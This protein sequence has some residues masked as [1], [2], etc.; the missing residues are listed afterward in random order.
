MEIIPIEHAT[1]VLKWSGKVI[2]TDPVSDSSL[3]SGEPEPDIILVTDIHGDHF[4]ID[5]LKSI[6]K[7]RTTV[8][9]P[10]IVA[11]QIEEKLTGTLVVMNNGEKV[12]VQGFAIEAIPMYNLPESPGVF[13]TKGRGNGY[14]LEHE[15]KRV[16]IPGDTSATPEMRDLKNIDIAFLCMNLPYTMS[17]EE[18]AQ[19]ALSFKPEEVIPYHYRGP[20]GLS[21]INAFKS[22]VNAGDPDIT[23]ELL[24]FYPR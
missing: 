14:V 17:V 11:D 10:K 8:V 12:E 15:G 19:A 13:H 4:N 6:V 21:D 5:T 16:Y 20:D 23:V 3:F 1:M 22:L 24:D 2:Y 7:E 18:A 9:V